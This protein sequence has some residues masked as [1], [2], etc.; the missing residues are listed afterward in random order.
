[1][2]ATE[3]E[4]PRC[5]RISFAWETNYSCAECHWPI[6]PGEVSDPY[7]YDVLI[8]RHSTTLTTAT[9][10]RH[11]KGNEATARRRA[12]SFGRVLAVVPLSREA[13]LQSCGEGRM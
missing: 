4:C 9:E 5:H 10:V 12:R 13:W 7:G 2:K 3:I 6:R 1:M 8:E 11:Y